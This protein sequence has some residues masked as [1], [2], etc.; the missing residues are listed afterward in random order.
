DSAK[1]PIN[2]VTQFI[3]TEVLIAKHFDYHQRVPTQIDWFKLLK[4]LLA[5][6]SLSFEAE[7]NSSELI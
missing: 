1:S 7:V 2:L 3:E 4:S 5:N 6:L